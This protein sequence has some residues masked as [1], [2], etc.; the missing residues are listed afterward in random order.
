MKIDLRVYCCLCSNTHKTEVELPEGWDHRYGGVDDESAGFCPD[1]AAVAAFAES[2]CPGCVG[3]WGDC[4]MW[5]AFSSSY[6]RK[7]TD[8]DL[9]SLEGGICPRRTNG[10]MSFSRGGVEK[11]DL[12]NRAPIEAG[13][14]FADAIRDYV[15]KYPSAA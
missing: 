15:K 5:R 14:A 7:I 13:K 6:N 10:T 4:D 8:A 1:H 2:Q 11:I 9:A 3:G 12:S